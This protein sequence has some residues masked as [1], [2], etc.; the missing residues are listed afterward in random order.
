MI[1]DFARKATK[2]WFDHAT[3]KDLD[4]PKIYNSVRVTI[5]AKF[6]STWRIR[7][8]TGELTY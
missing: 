4:K 5:G 6:R 7:M 2:K 1:R 3:G 8:L